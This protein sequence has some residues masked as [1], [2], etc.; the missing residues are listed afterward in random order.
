MQLSKDGRAGHG[1]QTRIR[2]KRHL[3]GKEEGKLSL[4]ADSMMLYIDIPPQNY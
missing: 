1:N 2:N 4:L 3:M